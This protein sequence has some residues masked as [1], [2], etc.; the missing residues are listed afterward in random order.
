MIHFLAAALSE[1]GASVATTFGDVA[2]A[3]WRS[4]ST[5]AS[6]AATSIEDFRNV[7]RLIELGADELERQAAR[8]G[9]KA[10]DR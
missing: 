2:Q 4:K 8:L 3:A 1:A 9:W 6:V 5:A 7:A 10:S